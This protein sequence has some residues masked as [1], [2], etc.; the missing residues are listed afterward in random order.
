[1]INLWYYFLSVKY[2]KSPIIVKKLLHQKSICILVFFSIT[3]VIYQ[4]TQ[5]H[6]S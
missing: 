1:M 5:S 3:Y 2:F 6:D 4:E